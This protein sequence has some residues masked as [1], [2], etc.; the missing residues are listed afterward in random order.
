[1]KNFRCHIALL[2]SVAFF[3][4]IAAAVPYNAAAGQMSHEAI[5]TEW[6][7]AKGWIVEP[8]GF[9]GIGMGFKNKE[10]PDCTI[11]IVNNRGHWFETAQPFNKTDSGNNLYSI[12]SL[13]RITVAGGS[14]AIRTYDLVRYSKTPSQEAFEAE[15][16][17]YYCHDYRVLVNAQRDTRTRYANGTDPRG[18]LNDYLA[19]A[20]AKLAPGAATG[21]PQP[22]I[23]YYKDKNCF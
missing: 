12:K 4:V 1:M 20:K 17:V 16:W 15:G 6:A 14:P 8:T 19:F 7:T 21:K 11:G 3:T 2:M 23:L 9:S 5:L 10:M 22:G 18:I 13:E